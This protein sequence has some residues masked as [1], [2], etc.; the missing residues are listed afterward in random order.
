MVRYPADS[1]PEVARALLRE[2]RSSLIDLKVRVFKNDVEAHD[3][4]IQ[5]RLRGEFVAECERA[6]AALIVEFGIP[7]FNG[8]DDN[9]LVPLGGV[10]RVAVWE[11]DQ[12]FLYVAA[13]HED[14]ELPYVLML[15]T[16]APSIA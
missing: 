12:Q 8:Y 15:G 4:E 16:Q 14:R 1:I 10:I 13:A 6:I 7:F 2:R 5:T 3:D 11:H 9:D